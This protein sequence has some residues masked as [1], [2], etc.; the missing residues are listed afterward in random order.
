MTNLAKRFLTDEEKNKID[1]AVKAAETKT[2]GEIVCLVES[3]S[4]RYPMANVIGATVIALP[5]A[6][7]LTPL[8]GGWLWIG[9]YNMWLFLGLFGLA[10]MG[11]Y[12]VVDHS[13]PLKRAFVSKREIEEEVEEAAIT[14]FFRHGLYRTKNANGILLFIS[15]FE[16]KVWVLAD[17]GIHTRVPAGQW[18]AIVDRVIAG[19]R[20]QRAAAAIC[21]AVETIGAILSQHF[22]VDSDDVNELKNIIVTDQ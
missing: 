19:I 22:P 3:A 20:N 15:V 8:I 21:E 17:H 18:D 6:L 5:L 7:I 11:T 12:M 10:F 4:Y 1:A 14:S 13:T 9:P 16:H 2:S